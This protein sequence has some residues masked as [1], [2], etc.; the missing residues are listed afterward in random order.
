MVPGGTVDSPG[1]LPLGGTTY[2]MTV[3]LA[4]GTASDGRLQ[5][6]MSTLTALKPSLVI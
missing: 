6:C 4:H 2:S 1:G 5:A 3:P